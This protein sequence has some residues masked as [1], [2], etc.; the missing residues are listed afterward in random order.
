MVKLTHKDFKATILHNNL[1][2]RPA[3]EPVDEVLE[4]ID[5]MNKNDNKD[6]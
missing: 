2:F 3:Y 1:K 4:F 5:V 6:T